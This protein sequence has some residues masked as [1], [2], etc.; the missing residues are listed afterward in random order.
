MAHIQIKGDNGTKS[1]LPG[2]VKSPPINPSNPSTPVCCGSTTSNV[3][4]ETETT[5]AFER[6]AAGGSFK[7]R[8]CII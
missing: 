3:N 6:D 5:G 1:V 8:V 4:F 7:V 2:S